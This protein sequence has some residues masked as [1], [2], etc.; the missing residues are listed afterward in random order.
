[1]QAR[2]VTGLR[3]V[4]QGRARAEQQG[5]E[6][7]G[8]HCRGIADP[9]RPCSPAVADGRPWIAVWAPP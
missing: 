3:G 8:T 9:R 5:G 7:E 4:G 2:A 6:Q 1:V